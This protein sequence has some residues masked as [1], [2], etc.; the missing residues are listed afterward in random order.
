MSF[1]FDNYKFTA[2]LH[3]NFRIKMLFNV[4]LM[5][6]ARR[7][8]IQGTPW[9]TGF[10]PAQGPKSHIKFESQKLGPTFVKCLEAS[11]S[12]PR[13]HSFYERFLSAGLLLIALNVNPAF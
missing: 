8:K 13:L 2:R 12:N 9:G 4:D 11:N 1:A 10:R 6:S 5:N 3:I 7:L